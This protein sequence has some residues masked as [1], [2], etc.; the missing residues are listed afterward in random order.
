[1]FNHHSCKTIEDYL[2]LYLKTDVL[3]L[4]DVFKT[5]TNTFLKHYKRDPLWFYTAQR[6]AWHVMLKKTKV[7]LEFVLDNSLLGFFEQQLR[8]G[9]S[10]VFH[11]YKEANNKYLPK[12][13][14]KKKPVI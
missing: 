7:N 3:H 14:P 12:Y 8:G 9:V 5:F 13:D 4:S 10:I 6:L 11:R 1:M 2:I